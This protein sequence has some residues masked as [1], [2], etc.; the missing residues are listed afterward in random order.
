MNE[1]PYKAPPQAPVLFVKTANTFNASGGVVELP[2][3]VSEIEVGATFGI[4]IWAVNQ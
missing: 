3:N 1:P 4:I 2:A